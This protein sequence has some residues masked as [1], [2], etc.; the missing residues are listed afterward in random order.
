[1]RGEDVA[2]IDVAHEIHRVNEVGGDAI[3][4]VE[5]ECHDFTCAVR[6]ENNLEKADAF[7]RAERRCRRRGL[8][9]SYGERNIGSELSSRAHDA[10]DGD[11]AGQGHCSGERAGV[12]ADGR[13]R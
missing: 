1:M 8:D 9:A 12:E 6:V 5:L 11:E 13:R 10:A 2:Y 3:V 4:V 7:V